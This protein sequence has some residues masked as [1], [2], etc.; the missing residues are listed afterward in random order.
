MPNPFSKGPQPLIVDGAPVM[1]RGRPVFEIA[2][3]APTETETKTESRKEGSTNLLP[4]DLK[5]VEGR[6]PDELRDNLELVEAHIRSIHQN[7]AGEL[8]ELSEVEN[9][10][11][12]MAIETRTQILDRL[13]RHAEIQKVFERKPEAVQRAMTNIRHDISDEGDAV[14]RLRNH[15]AR[16]RAL[17]KLDS[18]RE[19]TRH[20][21]A[22]E[23]DQ[24]EAL[25]RSDST[26]ARRIIVTETDDYRNA[27]MKL[28]T[29]SN[30]NLNVDE[31]RA[32]DRWEEFRAMSENT[33]TAGGFGI[34]V[35]IDPSII[36]TA[37]GSGNPFL[38]ISKQA[39]IN[40]NVWKGV[41]SAGVSWTFQTEAAQT[42]D[43]S[44]TL[45]QPSVTVHAARGFIPYSIE[46]GSDYPGFAS[47]IA[48]LLAEGYDEILVD[49]FT[50]G[51]GSGEP[52]GILTAISATAG[53]RVLEA[54]PGSITAPDPYNLWKALPQRYRRNASW[55]MSVGVNNAIRQLGTANVYHAYTDNLPAGWA[56]TLFN[57]GVYE[58]PYM[59]DTTTWTTTSACQ[60]IVGDFRNFL[61][62]KNGGM[63]TEYI[64]HLFQ[65]TTAGTG[66]GF[67]TGQRGI[68]AMA[69]IGSDAI[70]TAGFRVLVAQ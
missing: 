37:Q 45:A 17:R 50:R 69:R 2:G 18:D 13:A 40:T 24:V 31:Q 35:F 1:F 68:F 15:E 38:A 41:T 46:I 67:P 19:G 43:A 21:K 14:F 3:G 26:I 52:K 56:D 61:I 33:T 30:P 27:W 12:H 58:S 57:S 20:L 55:L 48:T 54:T 60:A 59:P 65:Q 28:M 42:T 23:K 62:V 11:M 22:D 44:P 5:Q 49:K 66:I 32:I 51:S 39:T 7:D 34:P 25:I 63:T 6:T 64:P 4:D 36:L 8:R 10:A 47:E 9:A 29:R 16:D 53:D 70:N